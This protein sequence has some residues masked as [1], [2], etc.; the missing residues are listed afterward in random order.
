MQGAQLKELPP[1][2][3]PISSRKSFGI[4]STTKLSAVADHANFRF[5]SH[6]FRS[7]TRCSRGKPSQE[8]CKAMVNAAEETVA[9]D[10][11]LFDFPSLASLRRTTATS[12]PLCPPTSPLASN[13]ATPPTNY[14]CHCQT[15]GL[16]CPTFW[17]CNPSHQCTPYN[18]S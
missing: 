15:G 18:I 4:L 17:N 11:T 1:P 10:G 12:V 6:I 5:I 9:T 13:G 2:R 8:Q 14:K 3:P 16:H 7:E